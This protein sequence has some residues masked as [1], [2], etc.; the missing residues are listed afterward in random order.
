MSYEIIKG[1]NYN[2][3]KVMIKS[4]SNNVTPRNYT[5]WECEPLT[6]VLK[7]KGEK[8]LIQEI[9]YDYWTGI[10]HAGNSNTFS[11]VA[12][13]F[14]YKYPDFTWSNT[15]K[16]KGETKWNDEVIKYTYDELKECMYN[17]Y[18][19]YKNRKKG[20]FLIALEDGKYFL[21]STKRSTVYMRDKEHAK[22][23]NS[24]EDAE[25]LLNGLKWHGGYK[26]PMVIAR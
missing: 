26:N 6:E 7:T 19:A 1:I 14:R 10:F 3:G 9:L 2:T 23:F 15:G 11:K 24:I 17:C 22:V 20:K 12:D 13:I 16:V 18:M 4:A 5:W 8:A 25:V 21:K